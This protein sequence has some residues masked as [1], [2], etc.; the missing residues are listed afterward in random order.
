M[1]FG[2]S[3]GDFIAVGSLAHQLYKDVFLVAR[4]AP[5][6][7]GTLNSEIGT[8]ALSIDLIIQEVKDKNSTLVRAGETRMRMVREVMKETN[9]TLKDLQIFSAKFDFSAASG[10]GVKGELEQGPRSMN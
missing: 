8:L 9:A 3:V 7:L 1:S 6:E 10:K 4:G 5:E 2:I